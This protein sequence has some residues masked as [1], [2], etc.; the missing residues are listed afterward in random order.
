MINR[1]YNA[2]TQVMVGSDALIDK[3][4]GDQAAGIYVPGFAGPVPGRERY[5]SV[6]P[7]IEPP[8]WI[9]INWKS[10]TLS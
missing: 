5:W 7:R 8:D 4:I 1:F 9:W 3:I 6:M 2:A 10:V